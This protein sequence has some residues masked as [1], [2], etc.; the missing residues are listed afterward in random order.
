MH[1]TGCDFALH[2]HGPLLLH[3]NP[4]RCHEFLD[5]YGHIHLTASG[6]ASHFPDPDMFLGVILYWSQ[7][8]AAL[9]LIHTFIFVQRK[10]K[11]T[12]G[13]GATAEHLENTSKQS[14]YAHLWRGHFF[15]YVEKKCK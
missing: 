3:C 14:L 7:I 12:L 15:L 4:A 11:Y 13:T 2:F 8:W 1:I 10:H 6:I 9:S 5:L